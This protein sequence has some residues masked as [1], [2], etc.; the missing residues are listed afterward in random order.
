MDSANY[1]A[2]EGFVDYIGEKLNTAIGARVT[3]I[4]SSNPRSSS[5]MPEEYAF[6]AI[7][8]IGTSKYTMSPCGYK[9]DVEII[10]EIIV[11]VENDRLGR[12]IKCDIEEM[13][14]QR[15]DQYSIFVHS[16]K[17]VPVNTTRGVR[18]NMKIALDYIY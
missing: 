10:V 5:D 14:L 3:T 8:E 1:I 2:S 11:L 4:F 13:F 16:V 9:R 15:F 17:T 18:H 6:V 12:K 7:N